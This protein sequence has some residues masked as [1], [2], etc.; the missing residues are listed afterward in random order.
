MISSAKEEHSSL[1]CLATSNSW[2]AG[3]Q[4]LCYM[5]DAHPYADAHA[6]ADAHAHDDVATVVVADS[7]AGAANLVIV[8]AD[9]AN[10]ADADICLAGLVFL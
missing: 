8:D 4:L 1:I 3:I 2:L 5:A 9:V 6:D 10:D 7:Y